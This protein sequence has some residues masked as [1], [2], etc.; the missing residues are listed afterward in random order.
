MRLIHLLAV[1]VVLVGATFGCSDRASLTDPSSVGRDSTLAQLEDTAESVTG[2]TA[3]ATF[4]VSPI[5]Q[6]YSD[7]VT[8]TTSISPSTNYDTVKFRIGTTPLEADTDKVGTNVIPLLFAPGSRIIMADFYQGTTVPVASLAKSVSIIKE[9]GTGTVKSD[10]FPCT[11][12]Y[13]PGVKIIATVTEN[14]DLYPGDITTGRVSFVDRET[15]R[16]LATKNLTKDATY[17][18]TRG[19]AEYCFT[20]FGSKSQATVAVVVSGN[21]QTPPI[22]PITLTK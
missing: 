7:P 19:T 17:M 4:M 9:D 3:T 15:L 16:T 2:T 1:V 6:R 8:A 21:Y 20:E 12:G 18:G 22:E 11:V 10:S 13:T 5:Q 14:Y